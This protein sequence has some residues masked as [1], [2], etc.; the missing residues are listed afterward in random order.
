MTGHV[1]IFPM[2][3][4]SLSL[5]GQETTLLEAKGLAESFF[6]VHGYSHAGSEYLNKWVLD[7]KTKRTIIIGNL[8]SR[9]NSIPRCSTT[10]VRQ[11]RNR[12]P[13]LYVNVAPTRMPMPTRKKSYIPIPKY[14]ASY[15]DLAFVLSCAN[16]RGSYD[17]RLKSAHPLVTDVTLLDQYETTTTFHI[18][19][20]SLEKNLTTEDIRPIREKLI[21]LAQT[22]FNAQLENSHTICHPH[23]FVR[24]RLRGSSL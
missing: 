15:E 7:W 11:F 9:R 3:L 10:R 19:Y 18:T 14:P 21:T 24:T 23:A 20:L 8:W 16:A 4:P 22:K 2:K 17:R 12:S 6:V 1:E 13:S 5:P